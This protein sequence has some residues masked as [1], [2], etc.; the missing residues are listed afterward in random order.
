VQKQKAT[1]VPH[2]TDL[3]NP[4]LCPAVCVYTNI[5]SSSIGEVWDCQT[6]IKNEFTPAA[7]LK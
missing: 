4:F 1:H 7:L 3:R 2:R 6:R 5:R